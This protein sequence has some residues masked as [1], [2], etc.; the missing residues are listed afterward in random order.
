MRRRQLLP[1][2]KRI[3]G[4]DYRRAPDLRDALRN[5]LGLSPEDRRQDFYAARRLTIAR[6]NFPLA[7]MVADEDSVTLQAAPGSS[8]LGYVLAEVYGPAKTDRLAR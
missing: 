8:R 3:D 1:P 2:G 7:L 6:S 5:F 4:R